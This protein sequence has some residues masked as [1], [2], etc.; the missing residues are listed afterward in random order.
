MR[1]DIVTTHSQPP[2]QNNI[3][4]EWIKAFQE[5]SDEHAQHNLVEHY[6]SL[7]ESLA[8]KFSKGK[9]IHEDFFQVGML[10][11]LAAIRRYD[12]SLGKNFESFAI[13]TI[14]G[15]IK[16]YIRDKTWS[17]Q[18]PR[19]I[20]E[21]GPKLT[22]AIDFLTNELERSPKVEEL[23][24]YLDVTE[25][26][27]LETM[28]MTRSYRALSIEAKVEG[29]YDGKIVTLLDLIGIHDNGFQEVDHTL[30]IEKIFS[31]LTERERQIINYTY[32]NNLSQKETGEIIGISQMHVSRLQR[33]ALIKLREVVK[34]GQ[35]DDAEN[36][37]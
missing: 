11:L 4:Y 12:E 27:I 30:L 32:F 18:V 36:I 37:S 17:V 24:K 23:A 7:V 35:H 1:W 29:D 14:I 2:K 21:L 20:K 34:L 13:P 19:R 31:I 3:V 9:A 22:K 26:E 5:T 33:R 8:R 10:G 15:E 25:E 16:R 6:Q 28:E